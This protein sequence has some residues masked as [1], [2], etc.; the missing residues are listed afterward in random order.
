MP[1]GTVDT[2]H[3]AADLTL[4]AQAPAMQ[5]A[6]GIS[7]QR[8]LVDAHVQGPF[9]KP[10]A[11]GTVRIDQLA[12][13]GTS[14]GSLAADLKGNQGHIDLHAVVN[15]LRIPGPKPDLLAAAPVVLDAGVTLDTPDRPATF[16]LAHK[17]ID[18]AGTAHLGSARAC[19]RI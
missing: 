6:A 14:I 4:H 8:V 15:D 11:T 1:S 13:P 12:A 17:L 18:L 2:V 19:R 9:T 3:E 5:P 10:D 7:W 16:H